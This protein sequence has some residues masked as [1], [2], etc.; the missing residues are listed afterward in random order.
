MPPFDATSTLCVSRVSGIPQS[1]KH[2]CSCTAALVACAFIALTTASMNPSAAAT[3]QGPSICASTL[4]PCAWTSALEECSFMR[5]TMAPKSVLPRIEL[6]ASSTVGVW[7]TSSF[8]APDRRA[9][10]SSRNARLSRSA[11]SSSKMALTSSSSPSARPARL[12]STSS[13]NLCSTERSMSWKQL[14]TKRF[15]EVLKY[16]CTIECRS[17]ASCS[18]LEVPTELRLETASTRAPSTVFSQMAVFT[19]VLSKYEILCFARHWSIT[20]WTLSAMIFL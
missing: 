12:F 11:W 1:A 19:V 10:L 6:R 18:V 8:T 9:T 16:A 13:S 2:P 3:F 20:V 7:A 15:T 5:R 17:F 14:S 4:Q